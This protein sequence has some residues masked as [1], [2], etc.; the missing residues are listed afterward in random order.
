MSRDI[1]EGIS[2]PL[3]MSLNFAKILIRNSAD[4]SFAKMQAFELE[5]NALSALF[6]KKMSTRRHF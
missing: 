3:V 2:K 6:E 5:I 4:L 1:E